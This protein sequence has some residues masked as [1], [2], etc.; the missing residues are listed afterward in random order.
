MCPQN[1]G[2]VRYRNLGLWGL[3]WGW[4]WDL[5]VDHYQTSL[6]NHKPRMSTT[7]RLNLPRMWLGH[8]RNVLYL[9]SYRQNHANHKFLHHH[10]K[11]HKSRLAHAI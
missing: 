8:P 4:G 1:R 10:K 9:L 11:R 6:H 7:E 2:F 3:L 5:C